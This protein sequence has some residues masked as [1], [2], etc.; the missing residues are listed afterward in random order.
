MRDRGQ[1]LV[2]FGLVVPV[3]LF[4]LLGIVD[5]G[6]VVWANDSLANAAREGAR[7]AIVHGG[8]DSTACPVGPVTTNRATT[9]PAA[10]ASCPYPSPSK[11]SIKNAVI[12]A[13]MA[14][15]RSVN[16]TVCYGSGCSGDTD[17][18]GAYNTR[19]TPITVAVTSTVDLVVPSVLGMS[20]FGI[21][22][23][24]TMVVNH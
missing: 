19:G 2:E 5:F 12:A 20:S 1:A 24:S 6:R 16:V 3:F 22:G 11:Q 23:S 8:S 17:A 9:V 15:G 7:Y 4:I 14:G 10:S 21:A 18:A 13:A